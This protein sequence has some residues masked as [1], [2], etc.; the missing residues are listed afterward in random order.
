MDKVKVFYF[1]TLKRRRQKTVRI[2][3]PYDFLFKD[4]SDGRVVISLKWSRLRP[5]IEEALRQAG[6][7]VSEIDYF[8]LSDGFQF[9]RDVH[10]V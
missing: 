10:E 7:F 6:C 4:R 2:S 3:F 8:T 9:I 1:D 5:I